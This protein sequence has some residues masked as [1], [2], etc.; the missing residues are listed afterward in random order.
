MKKTYD[1]EKTDVLS[2]AY[3]GIYN[4]NSEFRSKVSKVLDVFMPKEK[5]KE[6]GNRVNF[7]CKSE[8]TNILP[9]LE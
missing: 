7:A 8:N 9:N 3:D 5:S 4:T 2:S 1:A 6:D